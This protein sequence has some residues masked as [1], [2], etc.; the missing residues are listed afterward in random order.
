[1]TC[2]AGLPGAGHKLVAETM[3]KAKKE[4]EPEELFAA[5]G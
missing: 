5:A 1:L 4:K 2:P 3:I